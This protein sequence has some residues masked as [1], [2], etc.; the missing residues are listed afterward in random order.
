MRLESASSEQGLVKQFRRETCSR[1]V[2]WGTSSLDAG[3]WIV[4]SA[5][6]GALPYK[7]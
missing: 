1:R 7:R 4:L 5:G 6:K 2:A 3:Y